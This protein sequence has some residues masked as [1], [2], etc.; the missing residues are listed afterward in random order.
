MAKGQLGWRNYTDLKA[1]INVWAKRY[2]MGPYIEIRNLLN[3]RH[4]DY[5]EYAFLFGE[6]LL[7]QFQDRFG[8]RIRIGIQIF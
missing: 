8:R 2:Q 1:S 7:T 6:P 5:S 3:T 4:R